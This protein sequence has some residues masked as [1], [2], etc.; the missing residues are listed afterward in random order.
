MNNLIYNLYPGYFQKILINDTIKP[1]IFNSVTVIFIDIVNYSI[2]VNNTIDLIE[3]KNMLDL[4]FTLIDNLVV[5]YKLFKYETIGDA[6]VCIGGL[7]CNSYSSNYF[8]DSL[9]FCFELINNLDQILKKD[10]RERGKGHGAEIYR[11]IS[12]DI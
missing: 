9:N 3:I 1:K 11:C 2:T 12:E 6:N 10:V 4:L 7:Y 5:K 8:N